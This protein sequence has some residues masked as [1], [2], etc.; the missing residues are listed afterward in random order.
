MANWQDFDEALA[1]QYRQAHLNLL[2]RWADVKS[3]QIILKTALFAEALC[4]FR[5]FLWD[6]L[7]RNSNVIWIDI[8]AEIASKAK[9]RAA[10]YAPNSLEEYI[11]CDVRPLDL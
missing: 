5:A 8:S 10:H 9:A 4:P 3:S 1:E 11:T 6:M 7:Q 2:A